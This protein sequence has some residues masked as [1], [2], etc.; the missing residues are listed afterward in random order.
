MIN[1]SMASLIFCLISR[2][3]DRRTWTRVQTGVPTRNFRVGVRSRYFGEGNGLGHNFEYDF[4]LGH[5]FG[6]ACPPN[7]GTGPS[8]PQIPESVLIPGIL[9]KNSL[10]MKFLG[11]NVKK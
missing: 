6:N 3:R 1:A 8:R 5:R 9:R 11:Q 2:T 4:G 7:S 10:V